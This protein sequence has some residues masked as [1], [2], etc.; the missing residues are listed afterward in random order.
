MRRG[1]LLFLASVML[2]VIS[3]AAQAAPASSYPPLTAVDGK[4][5]AAAHLARLENG[6]VELA[7]QVLAPGKTIEAVRLDNLGGVSSLWRSDGKDKAAPLS[8]SHNGQTLSSGAQTMNLA[9]GEAEILLSLSLQD[10]GA[11]AGQATEFRLTVFFA[12]GERAMCQVEKAGAKSAQRPPVEPPPP[13]PSGQEETG[14][15]N[16]APKAEGT[17]KVNEVPKAEGAGKVNEAPK[18][19]ET[20]K[21]NEVPKAE[22]TGKVNEVSKAEETGKVNE[23]SKAPEP[24]AMWWDDPP[25][26]KPPTAAKGAPETQEPET[27]AEEPHKP[28]KTS[29][30]PGFIAVSDT[31]MPWEAAQA[32]CLQQGGRLPLVD[33]ALTVETYRFST[34][35]RIEG[36]GL[37]ATRTGGQHLGAKGEIRDSS[38]LDLPDAWYWTGTVFDGKKL[39]LSVRVRNGT[40]PAGNGAPWS[41][42]KR[43]AC[44][45]GGQAYEQQIG[46][47]AEQEEARK[48]RVERKAKEALDF[49]GII[50]VS[51]TKMTLADAQT[52]CQQKGGRVPLINGS[53]VFDGKYGPIKDFSKDGS[54]PQGLPD[55]NY[56]TGTVGPSDYVVPGRPPRKVPMFIKK[57]FNEVY[58][59]SDRYS[60]TMLRAICVRE[61]SAGSVYAAEER[62]QEEQRQEEARKAQEALDKERQE[63]EQAAAKAA[64]FIALSE[65]GM[66]WAE[67]KD[68]CAARGGRPPLVGGLDSF[69]ARD[70]YTPFPAQGTLIDGFGA[71]M[72][73]WSSS[74]LDNIYFWTGTEIIYNGPK[75]Y[76]SALAV[77]IDPGS[78]RVGVS[79]VVQSDKYARAICVPL[80]QS[81]GGG[82]GGGGG[83]GQ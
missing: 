42:P 24:P 2:S 58:L 6:L 76:S 57:E 35:S 75:E 60:D 13:P 3:G 32:Y 77:R 19:E 73:Y 12:N 14:K 65:A 41:E 71:A 46:K 68:W 66:P 44:F 67:V 51:D 37:L 45:W 48:A 16:E 52:F 36:F 21:V 20:G 34:A 62:R 69:D 53:D 8:V 80:G 54:W 1:F 17:G 63:K 11:F 55:A 28:E 30:S 81:G 4:P 39:A 5:K 38:P 29:E 74:G 43:A 33:K 40:V 56:W 7:L 64:G 72:D 79:K 27:T 10:N 59:Q 22:G 15:V 23:V 26:Q 18:A 47:L 61:K 25:T 83:G 31:E 78:A 82:S 70:N 50:A 9:A 49:A